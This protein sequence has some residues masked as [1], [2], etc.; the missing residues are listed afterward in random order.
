MKLVLGICVFTALSIT[1][2][3]VIVGGTMGYSLHAGRS[4]EIDAVSGA[5]SNGSTDSYM[6]HG[7]ALGVF[8]ELPLLSLKHG[9]ISLRPSFDVTIPGAFLHGGGTIL[10]RS[11]SSESSLRGGLGLQ[12]I[13]GAREDEK[14]DYLSGTI[15][16]G[17]DFGELYGMRLGVELDAALACFRGNKVTVE[18]QTFDKRINFLQLKLVISEIL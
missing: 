7:G 18:D 9:Y 4:T 10:Y 13:S 5:T 14:L 3:D 2:A 8:L 6:E 15:L 16:A 17:L 1:L 12:W 11:T